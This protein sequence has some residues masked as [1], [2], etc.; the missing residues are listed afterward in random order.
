M[1]DPWHPVTTAVTCACSKVRRELEMLEEKMMRQV[2]RLQASMGPWGLRPWWS[3]GSCDSCWA[4]IPLCLRDLELWVYHGLP[5]CKDS[6]S[7]LRSPGEEQSERFMDIMMHPLEAKATDWDL[8]SHECIRMSP[9]PWLLSQ[10]VP[11]GIRYT[12]A[13][14]EPAFLLKSIK[15]LWISMD[16]HGSW[17][18]SMGFD[19]FWGSDNIHIHH[20]GYFVPKPST[21]SIPWGGRPRGAS[22]GD[23]LQHRRVPAL[24]RPASETWEGLNFGESHGIIGFQ[25]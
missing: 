11:R 2:L 6:K 16:F 18:I 13:P 14:K 8:G 4:S 7:L 5:S 17:W 19:G 15:Q 25:Y 3:I 20:F 24:G 22:T 21:I 12:I 1:S 9:S 23:R 10:D